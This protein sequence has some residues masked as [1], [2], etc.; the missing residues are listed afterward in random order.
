MM[1]DDDE[2]LACG[3]L[4]SSPNASLSQAPSSVHSPKSMVII[5][6]SPVQFHLI[7]KKIYNLLSANNLPGLSVCVSAR[8]PACVRLN[9][10]RF[11]TELV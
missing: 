7:N 6:H 8:V 10:P 11:H 3:E 5:S 9:R 2:A 4:C 1:G